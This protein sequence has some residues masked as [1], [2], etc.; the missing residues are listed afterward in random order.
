LTSSAQEVRAGIK[1]WADAARDKW[2]MDAAKAE[3]VSVLIAIDEA[4]AV[5][6]V[7]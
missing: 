1:T 4:A 2:A 5:V 6:G 7:W 3:R